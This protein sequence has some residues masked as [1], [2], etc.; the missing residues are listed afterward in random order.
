MLQ[1]ASRLALLSIEGCRVIVNPTAVEQ[2][3]SMRI[4]EVI[5]ERIKEIR[6]LNQETQEQLGQRLG[7][8]LG[9]EWSRQAVSAAEKGGRAFT[10]AELVAIAYTLETTVPRLLTPPVGV[11]S[12]EMPGGAQVDRADVLES[13][14]PRASAEK[15]F[16][17]IRESVRTLARTQEQA[18]QDAVASLES[19]ALIDQQLALAADVIALRN[20]QAGGQD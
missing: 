16:E 14:L 20:Q 18:K 13:A 9:R 7:A 4:E 3:G 17:Q 1:D 12:I 2:G 6:E 8:V 11:R 10:A 5:G 19:L 15:V